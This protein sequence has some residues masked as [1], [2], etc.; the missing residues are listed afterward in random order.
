M[1]ANHTST[2]PEAPDYSKYLVMSLGTGSAKLYGHQV[3]FG[4]PLNWLGKG[5]GLP[6]L[7]DILF[8]ASDD[9]VDMCTALVL[10]HHNAMH[11]FLRIQACQP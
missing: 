10:G 1:T 7:V 11:N 8:R 9:M 5:K 6:P 3:G 2:I 4:G